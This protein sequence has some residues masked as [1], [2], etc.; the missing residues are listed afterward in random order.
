MP[1]TCIGVFC[2]GR[3]LLARH[4]HAF[5]FCVGGLAAPPAGDE[6]EDLE[7]ANPWAMLLR[8]LMPWINAGQAPDY[9]QQDDGASEDG[10]DNSYSAVAGAGGGAEGL[11][12][13]PEGP[14]APVDEEDDLD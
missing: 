14:H 10:S 5:W 13:E 1:F 11:A 12:G 7:A 9:D 6:P 8:T 2:L 4:I 3:A